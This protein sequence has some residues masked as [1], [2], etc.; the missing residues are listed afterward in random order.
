MPT[1]CEVSLPFLEDFLLAGLPCLVPCF[2]LVALALPG[3]GAVS[4]LGSPPLP[5]ALCVLFP[6]SSSGTGSGCVGWSVAVSGFA[7]RLNPAEANSRRVSARA[8]ANFDSSAGSS[9]SLWSHCVGVWSLRTARRIRWMPVCSSGSRVPVEAVVCRLC[10][11]QK[12]A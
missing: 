12:Y 6:L 9:F 11:I 4:R 1:S 5:G 3:S 7:S 10:R 2:S 8:S